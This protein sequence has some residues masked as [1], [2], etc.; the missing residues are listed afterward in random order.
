MRIA[1]ILTLFI[2]GWVT[3]GFTLFD[4][5][6][7]SF[8]LIYFAALPF[9]LRWTSRNT[10][11]LVLPIASSVFA[12]SVALIDDVSFTH[13]LSQA[14]LQALAIVFAGGVASIDWRKHSK[15][16]TSIVVGVGVPIVAYAGYQMVARMAHLP[17]AFL[18]I[19]NKQIYVEG[20]LQRDWDKDITRASSLFSEPSE[21]GLYCL[22]LVALGLAQKSGRLR[23]AALVLGIAGIL[24]SQ[25]LSA[26]LGAFALILVFIIS[27]PISRDTMRQ[28]TLGLLAIVGAIALMK[29]LVPDA[30][31]RLSQRVNE[32]IHLDSRAD[33][34]RVDHLPAI[35]SV[36]S[37]API[38]GH[39]ISSLA[40]ATS[41]GSDATTINYAMLLMER[42][43]LG[44][45]LFLIPWFGFTI[46]AW[47][48]PVDYPGRSAS[49]LLMV[50]TLYSFCTFSLTYFLPFWFAL[51]VAGS[52]VNSYRAEYD[53]ESEEAAEERDLE[54]EGLGSGP[55]APTS[56]AYI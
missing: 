36:V 6:R 45:T 10:G 39:G 44:A 34:G 31:D 16:L 12:I 4:V 30:F 15:A 3:A 22:W 42:G 8:P 21:L 7:Y 27:H 1:I 20:G 11:F 35:I 18:P 25:S 47:L 2:V 5:G 37:E 54:V 23:D 19:T 38:W 14:M 17:G 48:L 13:V 33:S 24:F 55:A 51:G 50:A 40:A 41:T 46:R 29:P 52:V 26:V 9:C 56:G 28:M 49:L 43:F 53:D 32:A